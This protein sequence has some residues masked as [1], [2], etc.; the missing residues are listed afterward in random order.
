VLG[1]FVIVIAI[2]VF[3]LWRRK[4]RLHL[5]EKVEFDPDPY[6]Y[7]AFSS[8]HSAVSSSYAKLPANTSIQLGAFTR[9]SQQGV[10]ANTLPGAATKHTA[11]PASSQQQLMASNLNESARTANA[12]QDSNGVGANSSLAAIVSTAAS[13]VP[14][15]KRE[16]ERRLR[17][18]QD[19]V[20]T[21]QRNLSVGPGP[22][23]GESELAQQ[24][25]QIALLMEEVERLREIVARDQA[26]PAYEE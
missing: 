23:S 25:Q 18:M 20:Q 4:R 19:T 17:Q 8:S 1:G 21:L 6:S 12:L 13:G 2:L 7:G 9:A 24:R 5:Q 14:P 16:R 26:L 15:T 22:D 11:T 10:R 3:L